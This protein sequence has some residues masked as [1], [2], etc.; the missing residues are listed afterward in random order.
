MGRTT[1][2]TTALTIALA[3]SAAQPLCAAD[4]RFTKI[5]DSDG[6]ITLPSLFATMNN[7][8]LVAFTGIDEEGGHAIYVSD[9]GPYTKVADGDGRLSMFATMPVINELGTVL[10]RAIISTNQRPGIFVASTHTP[11]LAVTTLADST[12]GFSS[13]GFFTLSLNNANVAAFQGYRFGGDQGVFTSNVTTAPYTLTTI[14]DNTDSPFMATDSPMI[15]NAG[16]VSFLSYLENGETAVYVGGTDRPRNDATLIADTTGPLAY[17]LNP[18][19]NDS[20]TVAFEGRLSDNIT[21]AVY[22]ASPDT[23]PNQIDPLFTIN[24]INGFKDLNSLAISNNG[25]V[26]FTADISNQHE[27][28]YVATPDGEIE[29][30]IQTG[31]AI[32]GARIESIFLSRRGSFNDSGQIVF[33]VGLANHRSAIYRADPIIPEPATLAP[34]SMIS[35]TL[36]TRPSRKAGHRAAAITPPT[37]PRANPRTQTSRPC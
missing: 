23:H 6:P 31:L 37:P 22:L 33:R 18:V 30:I 27:G 4:Y 28:L 29:K 21:K 34:T 5:A 2:Q 3:L 12:A 10:F 26:V 15:N 9:G 19:M 7:A 13:I 1:L 16:Q 8:G 24:P 11:A 14:A 35:I 32:D 25:S 36:F 20:A 17:I